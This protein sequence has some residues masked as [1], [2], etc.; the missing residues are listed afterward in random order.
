MSSSRTITRKNPNRIEATTTKD[1]IIY[2]S[3]TQREI[4]TEPTG[5]SSDGTSINTQEQTLN[6]TIIE[7]L[8]NSPPRFLENT[9]SKNTTSITVEWSLSDVYNLSYNYAI[10]DRTTGDKDKDIQLPYFYKIGVDLMEFTEGMGLSQF[11]WINIVDLSDTSTTSFTLNI[12]TSYNDLL[13][14]GSSIRTNNSGTYGIRVYPINGV[15]DPLER[16]ATSNFIQFYELTFESAGTPSAPTIQSFLISEPSSFSRQM[17]ITTQIND[18][19]Y[20]DKT[21]V[22]NPTNPPLKD[23]SFTMVLKDMGRRIIAADTSQS[24]QIPI[25]GEIKDYVSNGAYSLTSE[26]L[27][28]DATYEMIIAVRNTQNTS[29][30]DISSSEIQTTSNIIEQ[31]THLFTPSND[32]FAEL[33]G[34]A[35]KRVNSNILTTSGST[36]YVNI[37]DEDTNIYTSNSTNFIINPST[38]G[39]DASG[40]LILGAIHCSYKN[41]DSFNEDASLNFNGFIPIINNSGDSGDSGDSGE[42]GGSSGILGSSPPIEDIQDYSR[43]NGNIFIFTSTSTSDAGI[44]EQDKGY[45]IRGQT[46]ISINNISDLAHI[47][48]PSL[49][50][51]QLKIETNN[52]TSIINTQIIS[53]YVDDTSGTPQIDSKS[54]EIINPSLI[55][56]FGI[57]TLT[58][59]D[60]SGSLTTNNNGRY[61]L[62]SNSIISKVIQ[63]SN[64]YTTFTESKTLTSSNLPDLSGTLTVDKTLN[65]SE[66][67]TSGALPNLPLNLYSYH[68]D[69]NT[70]DT[71]NISMVDYYADKDS[72]GLNGSST[73]YND[74]IRDTTNANYYISDYGSTGV[75]TMDA[76]FNTDISN[77][78]GFQFTKIKTDD[79]ENL[80]DMTNLIVNDSTVIAPYIKGKYTNQSSE[81]INYSQYNQNGVTNTSINLSGQHNNKNRYFIARFDKISNILTKLEIKQNNTLTQI[82]PTQGVHTRIIQVK[83]DALIEDGDTITIPSMRDSD[84]NNQATRVLNPKEGYNSTNSTNLFTDIRSGYDSIFKSTSELVTATINGNNTFFVIVQIPP[85]SFLGTGTTLSNFVQL[86]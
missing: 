74:I 47:F 65:I 20:H 33:K 17:T 27:Y 28:L 16:R 80:T 13:Y 86:T 81:F 73:D 5:G 71:H 38:I 79:F 4:Y 75:S 54:F 61:V 39:S 84:D 41:T 64:N 45:L 66:N 31:R 40:Q 29:F 21:N 56:V 76:L 7:Y 67:I 82:T 11:P 68:T 49:D 25:N 58:H 18:P 1:A 22:D 52:D 14:G 8:I 42:P 46:D 72:L 2:K 69:Q 77:I 26:N 36:Y 34:H 48:P 43:N 63:T 32:T 15:N 24:I 37:N 50:T 85:S 44:N 35:N 62:P 30:G 60:L 55:H 53:F 70:E 78:S 57:S 12:D 23:V 9:S 6:N 83:T 10:R 51:Y 3:S 59:F 19:E